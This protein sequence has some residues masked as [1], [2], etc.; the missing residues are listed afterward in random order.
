[1]KEEQESTPDKPSERYKFYRDLT[2]AE[3]QMIEQ[4]IRKHPGL[5]RERA[6]M[7]IEAAGF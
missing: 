2:P 7:E 5:T 6:L 4:H 3:E 1:M